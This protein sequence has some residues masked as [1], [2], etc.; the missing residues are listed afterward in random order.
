M[1]RTTQILTTT[2]LV[3]VAI[4]VTMIA[5]PAGAYKAPKIASDD[6][7]FVDVFN[8]IDKALL[9]E[10]TT[11][12]RDTFDVETNA[13]MASL[14]GQLAEITSQLQS[15]QQT[16]PNA[17]AVFQQYQG[18]QEQLNT[19]ARQASDQYQVLI[20]RQIAEAYTAIYAAANEIAAQEGLTF[21]FATRADGEL[22]QTDNITG[23]T[24]EILARPL[25]TPPA[26]VDITE[27]V[28]IKLGYPEKAPEPVVEPAPET[29]AEA[30]PAP[31]AVPTT[32]PVTEFTEEPAKQSD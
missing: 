21:V 32:E 9:T 7:G 18:I 31:E 19:M 2:T 13:R 12:A 20:A 17:Q 22:I 30:A 16:D 8:L 27:L 5:S 14:E 23:I 1:K 28:R 11:A 3:L 4:I 24:Q 15:M 10:E 25:V 29:G 26:S 6:I